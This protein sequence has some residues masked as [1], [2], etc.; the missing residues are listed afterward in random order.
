M[1]LSAKI[2]CFQLR[3]LLTS[4]QSHKNNAYISV[5]QDVNF[6]DIHY[7]KCITKEGNTCMLT[8]LLL[9]LPAQCAREVD[10]GNVPNTIKC[11]KSHCCK[12][13]V[14]RLSLGIIIIK[15]KDYSNDR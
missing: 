12:Y 11:R 13:S 10:S 5:K 3:G 6:C 15:K 7:V 2:E 4:L 9:E 8:A 1:T 14:K